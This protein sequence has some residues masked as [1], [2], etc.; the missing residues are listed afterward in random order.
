MAKKKSINLNDLWGAC[1][2]TARRIEV[3]G[4]FI[5]LKAP[6][7]LIDN[8]RRLVLEAVSDLIATLSGKSLRKHLQAK[9]IED[10]IL[11]AILSEQ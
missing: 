10:K 11:R 1:S 3:L 8:S 5:E 9:R 4:E 2:K 7:V 6:K